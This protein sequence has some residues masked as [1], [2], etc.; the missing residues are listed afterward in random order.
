MKNEIYQICRR[1]T[2]LRESPYNVTKF[3]NVKL[4]I[5]YG[6]KARGV[7]SNNYQVIIALLGANIRFGIGRNSELTSNRSNKLL[8]QSYRL[9][10]QSESVRLVDTIISMLD[11]RH[12][13]SYSCAHMWQ[14]KTYGDAFF[15]LNILIRSGP[16]LSL[17]LLGFRV[18]SC[19]IA[20]CT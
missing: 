12:I 1:G 18:G 19:A 11:I 6:R 8:F 20:R 5:T 15:S 4:H 17:D 10:K 2:K 7:Q 16:M 14:G 3:D 9:A 13:P